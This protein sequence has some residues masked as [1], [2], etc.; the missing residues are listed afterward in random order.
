MTK[1]KNKTNETEN[2]GQ[3]IKRAK[4]TDI[5]EA[6]EFARQEFDTQ[7][8][9]GEAHYGTYATLNDVFEATEKVLDNYGI[10]FS[11][12]TYIH[13]TA[14]GSY[15]ALQLTVTHMPTGSKKISSILLDD[16]GKGPQGMGSA[17]TY[18]RRYLLQLTLNLEKPDEDDDGDFVSSGGSKKTPRTPTGGFA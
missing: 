18:Y 4:A 10:F 1:E 2:V 16:N 5:H 11:F 17:I 13:D 8:M 14:Y 3:T 7:K 15:N 12:N 9:S 6:L